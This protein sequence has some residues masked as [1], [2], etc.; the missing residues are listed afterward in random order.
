MQKG[1]ELLGHEVQDCVTN[2]KGIVTSVSY[3]LYGCIQCLVRPQADMKKENKDVKETVD[4]AY[5]F[6][7]KRLTVL[8]KKPVM[9]PPVF[10]TPKLEP[11]GQH[12]MPTTR[13]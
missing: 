9:T 5:W 11:G 13:S 12:D 8:S 6:D 10:E 7:L 1:M 3:E 4:T 2:V